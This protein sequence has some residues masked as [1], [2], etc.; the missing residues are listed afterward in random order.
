MAQPS[1]TAATP[2]RSRRVV[3]PAVTTILLTLTCALVVLFGMHQY[4]DIIGPLMLTLN[5]FIAAYPIQTLLIRKG[6]PKLLAQIILAIVVFAILSAFFFALV[7]SIT[8]LVQELPQYQRQFW[9]LYHQTVSWLSQFGISEQQVLDQLKTLNPASFTGILSSA[10]GSVTNIVTMLT[11][12]IVMIFMM[13]F[14]TDT[15]GGRNDA[16]KR[17]QPRIWHSIADFI[18]GVRRYW[19]VS[20]IFGLIVAI[21]DVIALEFLNVPLALVWGILAFLTNYIP[22]VGFVI[23]LVPPAIMALLANDP[24]T[25]LLVVI[26]YSV[27]NFVIQSIIQPKFNGDAVGVTALVSFLSLLLWSSVIGALGALLALPMTLLAKAILVDHDPQM[28]W[29][30]AFISNDPAMADPRVP[31]SDEDHHH[32]TPAPP[33]A[34]HAVPDPAPAATAPDA[35]GSPDSPTPRDSATS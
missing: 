20:T 26:I 7:W 19:V 25:A 21:I 35:D 30:N 31:A 1:D 22:N 11:V 6:V 24:L 17:Y 29:L 32:G 28:R 12:I 10:L 18:A 27:V 2:P 9:T 3:I 34:A 23:G 4:A 5:L 14:D 16:L 8:A 33:P 13:A 15:F